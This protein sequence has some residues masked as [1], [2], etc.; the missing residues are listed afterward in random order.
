MPYLTQVVLG[1]PAKVG[2]F[3]SAAGLFIAG[4]VVTYA[5]L[6][7]NPAGRRFKESV[8]LKIP[9]LGRLCHSSI[10]SKMA[11]AM[12]MM[13]SAGCDMPT[14]LRL[15]STTSGSE[16]VVLESNV[17]AGQIEEGVN[18]LEAGQFCKVIP[19]LFFCPQ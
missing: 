19:R 9:I 5:V 17:L 6:S 4:I 18:I 16:M 10:L 8:L 11:E 13:V 12:A 2:F 14:T 7:S 3:R 1:M 15:S